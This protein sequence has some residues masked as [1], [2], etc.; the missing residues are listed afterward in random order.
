MLNYFRLI[1]ANVL[2]AMEYRWAFVMQVGFMML[3]NLFMLLI[4]YLFFRKF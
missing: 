2:S 4:W 3:N 1:R